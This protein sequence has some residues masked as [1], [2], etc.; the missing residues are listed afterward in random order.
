MSKKLDLKET[1]ASKEIYLASIIEI[2]KSLQDLIECV[3][4]SFKEIGVKTAE[5][6]KTKEKKKFKKAT[7]FETDKIK[8]RFSLDNNLLKAVKDINGKLYLPADKSWIVPLTVSNIDTLAELGFDIEENLLIWRKAKDVGITS[9]ISAPGL[10]KSNKIAK[11][12]GIKTK[13]AELEK[14]IETDDSYTIGALITL[15]KMQTAD[16]QSSHSTRYQNN[17]GFNAIDSFILTDI[18]KDYL[19]KGVLLDKQIRLIRTKLKKYTKQLTEIGITPVEIKT[20]AQKKKRKAFKTANILEDKI[21]LKFSYDEE[22]LLAVKDIPGKWY[23]PKDKSWTVPRTISNVDKLIE[24]GFDIEQE[25]LDWRKE[26]DAGITSDINVPGLDDVLRPFQKIAV[27]FIESR[28]GRV[29]IGDEMG[30]GKTLETIAWMVYK[31][32]S[33]F[34]ILIVCP[35]TLK[36]NWLAE[37]RKWTNWENKIEILSGTTPYPTTKPIAII[38]YDIL[39]EWH[40]KIIESMCPKL[41][42]MDE[43]HYC[44]TSGTIYKKIDGMRKKVINTQRSYAVEVIAKNTKHVIGLTGTPFLNRP[45]EIFNQIRIINPKLFPSFKSFGNRYCNPTFNGFATVY[46]GASR[47]EE[48]HS[49]LKTELMIRR[50]KEDVLKELP[51]KTYTFQFLEIDNERE[52]RKAEEEIIAYLRSI[53][54]KKADRARN[55]EALV[56]LNTLRQLVAVGKLKQAISWISDFIENNKLVVFAHHNKVISAIENAFKGQC[57]KIDG[58]VSHKKRQEA[59]E[60]FQETDVP[61]F[62]GNIQAAGVG[63]TLTA[64]SHACFAEYPWSPGL[65]SQACDR[66]HR[67]GQKSAVT[68][69]N[70][71]ASNTIEV[72]MVQMLENKAKMFNAVI[73][74]NI[75]E[76]NG[77]FMDLINKLKK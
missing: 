48:L 45:S 4:K 46:S 28:N 29:L 30:L 23:E 47:T 14:L 62:I 21:K 60:L 57:V 27:S 68:I 2:Q 53:D 6:S 38:N 19:R 35:A 31:G 37:F 10:D 12:K 33:I 34:P 11:T 52:Y 50:R 43:S 76:D 65:Y 73:D 63:I 40:E 32:K 67:I 51:E 77:L 55:A 58:S 49:I 39:F 7:I 75:E 25:L 1:I 5:L 16:E 42:V 70:L 13:R 66:V 36:L 71:V 18:S 9:D 41:M 61:L 26:M 64:T 8:L 74:G 72:D 44:K 20:P 3:K 15:Y 17:Y 24:M 22:V 69:W 59:V 56:R 54:T